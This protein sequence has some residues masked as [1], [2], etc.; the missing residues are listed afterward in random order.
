MR[1]RDAGVDVGSAEAMKSG[2]L[3]DVTS[4]W[5]PAVRRL[6]G[7]FAGV[8]A[9][10]GSSSAGAAPLLAAT[11]DG[12]GTKLHVEIGRAHV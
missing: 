1:Y 8:M 6:T 10:P 11:M 7:G 5:T 4:T 3:R 9:W 12:V 2:M